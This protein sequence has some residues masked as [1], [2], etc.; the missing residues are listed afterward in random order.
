MFDKLI[1]YFGIENQKK[2]EYRIIELNRYIDEIPERHKKYFGNDKIYNLILINC[3][4]FPT[5]AKL[6]KIAEEKI[7]EIIAYF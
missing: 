1:K 7:N 2:Y 5:V 4:F 3:D 6:H